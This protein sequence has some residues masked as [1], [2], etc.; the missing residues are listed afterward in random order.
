MSNPFK[1]YVYVSVDGGPWFRH[2]ECA[3]SNAGRIAAH[4]LKDQLK[5]LVG[6]EATVKRERREHGAGY[7]LVSHPPQAAQP[8][9]AK[10]EKDKP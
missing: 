7:R 5:A 6:I 2:T 10:I 9:R 4:C 1:Y 3:N 8:G